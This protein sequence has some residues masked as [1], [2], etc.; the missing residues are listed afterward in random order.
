MNFS[1]E[2][3]VEN[4]QYQKFLQKFKDLFL[5]EVDITTSTLIDNNKVEAQIITREPGILAGSEEVTYL[6]PE[7]QITFN[8]Q[9][10]DQLEANSK[11]AIIKGLHHQILKAERLILNILMRMSG[12]AT[13]TKKLAQ[14]AH[15]T[16]IAATRKTQWHYLDKKAVAL[17]GGVTHR[18]DLGHA[19]LIKENHLQGLTIKKALEKAE[20]QRNKVAFIEIEVETSKEALEANT[21]NKP[22]TI[23]LDNFNPEQITKLL[24]Q[25]NRKLHT[26]EASGGINESNLQEY[27]R[28]APDIISMSSLTNGVKSLDLSLLIKKL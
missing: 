15:P 28:T 22:L 9:D 2:L 17:G 11:L 21:H 3:S 24:P 23:M 8:Y 6:F 16:K 10:G 1:E 14:I 26:I 18:L 12:I 27:S 5:E 19:I 20:S 4:P 25:L 13:Y 7:L